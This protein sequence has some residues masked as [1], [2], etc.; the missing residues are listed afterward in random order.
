MDVTIPFRLF[1]RCRTRGIAEDHGLQGQVFVDSQEIA[2]RTAKSMNIYIYL[3]HKYVQALYSLPDLILNH[4]ILSFPILSYLPYLSY[5]AY[6]AYPAYLA[7]LSCLS[8]LE[9]SILPVLSILS[10]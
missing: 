10:I 4:I 8:Y 5:L 7:Y 3:C 9:L 6:L 2:I 1:R